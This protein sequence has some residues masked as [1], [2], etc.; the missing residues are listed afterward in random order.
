[1]K[2][3]FILSYPRSGSNFIC[4][5]LKNIFQFD[6][7]MPKSHGQ[8]KE[9]W[10]HYTDKKLNKVPYEYHLKSPLIFI[11]RN[12]K[13]SIPR[14]TDDYNFSEKYRKAVS[15]YRTKDNNHHFDYISILEFYDKRED[16]KILIYYEDFMTN[17]DIELKKICDFVA[18]SLNIEYKHDRFNSFI[19]NI[20]FH[21]NESLKNYQKHSESKTKGGGLEYHSKK[22]KLDIRY[23]I[24]RYMENE[25]EYLYNKY[26][27]RYALT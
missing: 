18:D 11:M 14:Q 1:M 6:S 4:Y 26:L 15:N 8:N 27:K 13:E 25:Y 23:E 19:E 21:K 2:K 22:I 10:Y 16:P 24:D 17:I 12:Y 9:F 7:G 20:D 3:P 5:C